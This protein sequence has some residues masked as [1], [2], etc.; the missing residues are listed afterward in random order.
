MK[1]TPS[2]SEKT[3]GQEATAHLRTSTGDSE[4]Q[5]IS[6][7]PRMP[8]IR[9]TPEEMCA[10]HA[11][12]GHS[13]VQKERNRLADEIHDGLA[14]YFSA[15]CLQL[16]TAKEVLSSTE[17]DALRS[18]KQAIE[19][20]N[21][22]LA[23]TRRCIHNSR[24]SAVDESGLTVALQRLAE[25][26]TAA[27]RLGCDFRFNHIPENRLPAR[28][29]H[30]LL[31]IAQEAIHNA[32]RHANPTLIVVTLRWDAPNLLLQVK[33]NGLGIS[34]APFKKCEGF[35]LANMRE[36][37]SEIAARFEIQTAA[38]HGTTIIVTVPVLPWKA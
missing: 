3:D 22:G 16:A 38:G 32:V 20:A 27:G 1:T 35:G 5:I 14:Q 26:W 10:D 15:I 18:I 19:S 6:M 30:Q 13:A 9:T 12:T 31:R 7:R 28:T 34:T 21:L 36:R 29:K 2:Q 25:R 37:A 8:L 17:S 11:R 33:D 24:L 23:E 4:S